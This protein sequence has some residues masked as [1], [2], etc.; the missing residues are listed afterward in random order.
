MKIV[1]RFIWEHHPAND[2][3]WSRLGNREIYILKEHFPDGL[4]GVL[5]LGRV[6]RVPENR[7]P[8]DD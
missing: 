4:V 7:S 2:I 8:R 3:S 5:E 6:T 1:R